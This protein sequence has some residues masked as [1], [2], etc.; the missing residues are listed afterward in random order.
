MVQPTCEKNALLIFEKTESHI[1]MLF[2][3]FGFLLFGCKI[4][5]QQNG[6]NVAKANHSN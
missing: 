5:N 3:F 2:L 6:K 1:I 4:E